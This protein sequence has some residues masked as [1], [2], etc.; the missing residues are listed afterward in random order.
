VTLETLTTILGTGISVGGTMAVAM[1]WAL[2]MAMRAEMQ[3]LREAMLGLKQTAETLRDQIAEAKQA[4]RE[5]SDELH[6][7]VE[8][9]RA[10][11]NNHE[12]RI[13]VLETT[14]PEPRSASLRVRRKAS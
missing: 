13:T 1:R 6:E 8:A 3:P 2:G 5:G 4:Q 9:I 11:L 12:T 10:V 14:T 7:A